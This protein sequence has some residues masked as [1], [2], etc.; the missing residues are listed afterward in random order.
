MYGIYRLFS[1]VSLDGD[2]KQ[3]KDA[4]R[5]ERKRDK[6][7][8]SAKDSIDFKVLLMEIL[9]KEAYRSDCENVTA[10]LLFENV[11]YETAIQA[12]KQIIE[13]GLFD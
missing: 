2:L 3:L 8:Q 10:S 1:I 7:C 13:S 4:V 12:L 9:D 6:Q 5:E 11:S